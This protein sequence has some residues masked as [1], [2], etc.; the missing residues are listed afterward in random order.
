MKITKRKIKFNIKKIFKKIKKLSEQADF[1]LAEECF[2]DAIE[3]YSQAW[4]LI[5]EPKEKYEITE[6]IASN[7]GESLF[8]LDDFDEAR[9]YF[10][11]AYAT[12]NGWQ[13][14]FVLLM[15]GK[16]WL[17]LGDKE[18]GIAY[19]KKAYSIGGEE[20]FEDNQ[21]LY[22]LISSEK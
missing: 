12:P 20:I 19:L 11:Q 21:D 22:Q 14:P 3:L 15:L 7:L 9:F 2:N 18:K 4:N 17:E 1:F 10:E 6:L 13:N 8:E 5:P 16:C